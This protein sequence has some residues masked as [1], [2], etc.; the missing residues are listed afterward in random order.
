[1]AGRVERRVERDR[2]HGR[3]R[4]V[5]PVQLGQRPRAGTQQRL[6]GVVEGDGPAARR[7]GHRTLARRVEVGAVVGPADHLARVVER[8][9]VAARGRGGAGHGAAAPWCELPSVVE[10][11]AH[12]LAVVVQPVHAPV[13][14]TAGRFARRQQAREPGARSVEVGGGAD[15]GGDPRAG[16][17]PRVVEATELQQALWAAL[18]LGDGRQVVVRQRRGRLRDPQQDAAHDGT[19]ALH[20]H[21]PS[22][23]SA[24]MRSTLGGDAGDRHHRPRDA[25]GHCSRSCPDIAASAAISTTSRPNA[26]P[27]PASD[28]IQPIT[29]GPSRKPA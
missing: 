1:M 13:V 19:Q 27:R 26:V 15:V 28:A 22:P 14:E 2:G 7:Q 18:G 6:T 21:A 9:R 29:G 23:R 12:G 24:A 17:L 16:Q 11:A 10:A 20:G 25:E 3:R 5:V 4:D 8:R